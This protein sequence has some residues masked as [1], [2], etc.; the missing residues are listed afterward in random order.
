MAPL[1]PEIAAEMAREA[2]RTAERMDNGELELAHAVCQ[3]AAL[4]ASNLALLEAAKAGRWFTASG[5]GSGTVMGMGVSAL[6]DGSISLVEFVAMGG[7]LAFA[8]LCLS[9]ALW[10]YRRGARTLGTGKPFAD[11]IDVLTE[12]MKRRGMM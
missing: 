8:I 2:Q 3:V 1:H 11:S 7:M 6:S 10:H 4:A 5:V 12:E 9:G